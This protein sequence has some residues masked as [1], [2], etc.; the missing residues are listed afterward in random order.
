MADKL[1]EIR[2]TG[3]GMKPGS[4]RSKELAEI[5][6]A[7]ED[8]IVSV[9][10]N[11]NPELQKESVIIGLINI[12]DES[13]GLQFDPNLEE[14]TIPAMSQI[15]QSFATHNFSHLPS[16]T[17]KPAQKIV[18][19]VK[20]YQ[21]EAELRI[22]NG[23]SELKAVIT[24]STEIPITLPLTGETTL[25][26]E[27]KRVGGVEPKVTLKTIDGQT[28]YCEVSQELAKELGHRL[29][30]QVALYGEAQWSA[31]TLQLE[32]FRIKSELDYKE[33][34]IAEAFAELRD[35]LGDSFDDIEDV[36]EFVTDLRRGVI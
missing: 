31:D 17:A 27:I 22:H 21:C 3:S 5:I 33:T 12:K 1:L 30:T 2:F 29:Y 24:P 15:T 28:V 16:A 14:L 11:D 9:V 36:Q 8:M 34:P 19:F 35:V 25:Y 4:I 23:Q 7:F 10:L 13:I 6:E 20:K 32:G 26:G 18:S